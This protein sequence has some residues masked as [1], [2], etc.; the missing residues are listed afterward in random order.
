MYVNLTG[1]AAQEYTKRYA[2]NVPEVTQHQLGHYQLIGRIEKIENGKAR[3]RTFDAQRHNKKKDR[4]VVLIADVDVGKITHG[5]LAEGS[6]IYAG[7]GLGEIGKTSALIINLFV[8]VD[9]PDDLTIKTFIEE[10]QTDSRTK[11]KAK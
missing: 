9:E 3:I 10:R 5:G 7:A 8:D 6:P 2:P 1:N 11:N 4:V